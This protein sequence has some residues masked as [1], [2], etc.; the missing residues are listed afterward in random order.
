M[1]AELVLDA[2][3]DHVVAL[4][5]R[6]VVVD[7]IFGHQKQRDAARARRRIGQAGEHEMHDVVRHLVVAVGDEDLG[8]E[9]AIGA[10]GLRAR[11]ASTAARDRSPR[12]ARSGSS[13]RS[14]RR[15]PSSA[16]SL[17]FSSSLP[18]RLD[19]V[20]GAL[21]QQR[22]Q[23][24][25][26]VRGVPDLADR[27][28]HDL[29]AGPARPT[30]PTGERAPAAFDELLVGVLPARRGRHFSVRPASSR[31]GRRLRSKVLGPRRRTCRPPR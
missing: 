21:G 13:C 31:S 5:E 8:A 20:D 7:E 14:T 30:P 23:P 22:A 26:D 4:A 6:A 3:A 18:P 2:G 25:R 19:G 9:D 29:A 11:R 16:G 27:R 10:V 17:A 28:C 24:E 1:D 12:A 15:P